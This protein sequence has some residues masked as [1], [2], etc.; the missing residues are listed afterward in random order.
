MSNHSRQNISIHSE[1]L[2][3]SSHLLPNLSRFK[4]HLNQNIDLT[5]AEKINH[6]TP[7]ADH[8]S[9]GR[10]QKRN[11]KR[12]L[13]NRRLRD[14]HVKSRDLNGSS[15]SSHNIVNSNSQLLFAH[16]ISGKIEENHRNLNYLTKKDHNRKE[17]DLLSSSTNQIQP[18][19]QAAIHMLQLK[20][21]SHNSVSQKAESHKL[22]KRGSQAKKM[23]ELCST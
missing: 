8:S 11:R 15:S 1:I 10:S 23:L 17:K 20:S 22:L 21:N 7:I 2:S 4:G 16:K 13:L 5:I 6:L 18:T 14:H 12:D 3:Q 9:H 19:L